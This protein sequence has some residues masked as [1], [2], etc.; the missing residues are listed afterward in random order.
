MQKF[1]KRFNI[2]DFE[3]SIEEKHYPE[4]FT[5]SEIEIFGKR[6]KK[7]SLA[8]RYL[9]KNLLIE[10]IKM[11]LKYTEIEIL[12]NSLGKPILTIKKLET[13]ELDRLKFSISHSKETAIVLLIMD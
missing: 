1:T 11:S 12:N 8:A 5:E 9:L 13:K 10:N 3:N 4:Y 2:N 6:R 7:G